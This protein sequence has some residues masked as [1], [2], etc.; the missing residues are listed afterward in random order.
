MTSHI[1]SWLAEDSSQVV[2]VPNDGRVL[3]PGS[4][5]EQQAP[6]RGIPIAKFIAKQDTPEKAMA[7]AETRQ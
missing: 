2:G 7:S 1:W 4:F 5:N 6:V 3:M